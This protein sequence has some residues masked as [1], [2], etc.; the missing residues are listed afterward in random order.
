MLNHND[1]NLFIKKSKTGSTSL[2]VLIKCKWTKKM[3]NFYKCNDAIQNRPQ[4]LIKCKWAGL[5]LQDCW[6]N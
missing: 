2:S 5:K 4:K 6:K 3:L 1:W